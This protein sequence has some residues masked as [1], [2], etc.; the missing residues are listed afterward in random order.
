M[1]GKVI[2]KPWAASMKGKRGEHYPAALCM[3]LSPIASV[4]EV[5]CIALHA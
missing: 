3:G 5:L 2:M 4:P 1:T